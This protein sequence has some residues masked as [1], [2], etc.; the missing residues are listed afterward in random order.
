MVAPVCGLTHMVLIDIHSQEFTDHLNSVNNDDIKWTTEGE[1]VTEAPVEG[2][3]MAG[4]EEICQ[5]RWKEH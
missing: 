4:D 5:S 2:S 1:V 3:A